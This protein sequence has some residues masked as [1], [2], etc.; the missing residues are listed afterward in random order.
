MLSRL[1]PSLTR[2]YT[3]QNPLQRTLSMSTSS[4]QLATFASGCFWGTEHIFLKH[5][6]P[7]QDKGVLKTSV[8]YIGGKEVEGRTP[9]YREVC[10]GRTGHAE[11]MQVEFDPAKVSYEEL[12]G[13]YALWSWCE[14]RGADERI[15]VEFFYKT[16]D[17]TTLNSQGADRGTRTSLPLPSPPHSSQPLPIL[18]NTAPRYSR[19]R[20]SKLTL[21]SE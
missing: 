18:Q 19:T 13:A 7:A 15:C 9:D 14:G 4:A 1:F 12:V 6:P 16:H 21:L 10:T 2:T 5:Y 8:G 20:P 11:A 3:P 17:P